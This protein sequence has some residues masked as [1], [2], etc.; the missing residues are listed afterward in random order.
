MVWNA[1][2]GDGTG[3]LVGAPTGVAGGLVGPGVSVGTCTIIGDAAAP[4][5]SNANDEGLLFM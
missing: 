4:G 2:S 1:P 3:A 5:V